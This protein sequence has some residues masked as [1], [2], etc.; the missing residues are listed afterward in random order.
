VTG[1]ACA[2]DEGDFDDDASLLPC[3]AGEAAATVDRFDA[4]LLLPCPP[5]EAVRDAI[6]PQA[7]PDAEPGEAAEGGGTAEEELLDAERYRSLW[8]RTGR[9]GGSSAV[10]E[11][12]GG[13]AVAMD[14]SGN[15]DDAVTKPEISH[16]EP[17]AM[18]AVAFD[19]GPG[20]GANT[21][22]LGASSFQSMGFDYGAV[23]S[24]TKAA[25]AGVSAEHSV[26]DGSGSGDTSGTES[27]DEGRSDEL[28]RGHTS[29]LGIGWDS[30]EGSA[31]VQL[32]AAADEGDPLFH[33]PFLVPEV[34]KDGLPLTEQQHQVVKQTADYVRTA[35]GQS[36][37]RI[38]MQQAGNAFFAFL[39]PGDRLHAYYRWMLR[40]DP[41]PPQQG[42][43]VPSG[44]DLLAATYGVDAT[45]EPATPRGA[46]VGAS[47][48]QPT[49]PAGPDSL[50][51]QYASEDSES[52][53]APGS[54]ADATPS[55]NDTSQPPF[56]S[57]Q[58]QPGLP[59]GPSDG[60]GDTPGE[61]Q[62]VELITFVPRAEA[63]PRDAASERGS[64][65]SQ[66]DVMQA[67]PGQ[68]EASAA[69]SDG[70]P[71]AAEGQHVA[72][73]Q[74]AA[75]VQ[76]TVDGQAA[77]EEQSGFQAEATAKGQLAAES[78]AAVQNQPSVSGDIKPRLAEGGHFAPAGDET[79]ADASPPVSMEEGELAAGEDE[80]ATAAQELMPTPEAAT[81][82]GSAEATVVAAA[83]PAAE[84]EYCAAETA[85]A[86]AAFAANVKADV[87]VAL[88]AASEADLPQEVTAVDA[89]PSP[90]PS[91][92]AAEDRQAT[93]AEEGEIHDLGHIQQ[94]QSA[95]AVQTVPMANHSDANA[96]AAAAAATAA[97][98]AD[99]D[100]AALP[101]EPASM[102]DGKSPA[103][104]RLASVRAAPTEGAVTEPAAQTLDAETARAVALAEVGASARASAPV[105]AAGPEEAAGQAVAPSGLQLVS[106][107][108]G[109][110]EGVDCSK[111]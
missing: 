100:A 65:K 40:T 43:E 1:L 94:P 67:A 108:S 50:L 13:T 51:Q 109:D 87:T 104:Q 17:T 62:S 77:S 70:F 96:A 46:P 39:S 18:Q 91:A 85:A 88:A 29:A 23:G 21:V 103:G 52:E 22:P 110:E 55:L 107:G 20:S 11:Q 73:A 54:P 19:Y 49:D 75:E 33:P 80:T 35:G 101:A 10:A 44:L 74:A 53:G 45:S 72:E 97:A 42:P 2:L 79:A 28:E 105:P 95:H 84:D 24:M 76:H 57:Q 56:P 83:T 58:Q 66:P 82:V 8:R 60:G 27:S 31:D 16:R 4:R 61:E 86:A 15:E 7:D 98:A 12:N 106:Y 6:R 102:P 41:Q 38:G 71:H 69:T 37:F 59:A 9:A 92:A 78:Q 63:R 89:S 48:H 93:E 36:E 25:E 81:A 30:A 64:Q 5:P 26:G 34:L 32:E 99:G 68:P 3:F 14:S 111:P 90:L 47:S